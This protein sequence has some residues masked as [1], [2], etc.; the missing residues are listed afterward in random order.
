ML[1]TNNNGLIFTNFIKFV[2]DF[3]FVYINFDESHVIFVD[4]SIAYHVFNVLCNPNPSM[5]NYS[6]DNFFCKLW[7]ANAWTP[8]VFAVLFF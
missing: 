6:S 1:L 4:I 7:K 2:S 3:E 8:T 5:H